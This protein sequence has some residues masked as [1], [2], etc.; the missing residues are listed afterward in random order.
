ME[1]GQAFNGILVLV[2]D[3]S[4]YYHA[5]VHGMLSNEVSL[6]FNGLFG[7][8]I[9]AFHSTKTRIVAA[10]WKHQ[11]GEH[12]SMDIMTLRSWLKPRDGVLKKMR[13]NDALTP[14]KRD[15]Y[16]CEWFQR[17][18]LDFSRSQEDILSISGPEGSG[19]T[20]LSQWIVE[21]LQRPLG[22]KSRM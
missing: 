7:G 4:L 19:K 17:H 9:R 5:S 12:E 8:Q 14:A 11:L 1:V 22:K 20:Y 3:V 2:R 16:T 15:E 10:M 21:R 18:L 6:D 13:Q